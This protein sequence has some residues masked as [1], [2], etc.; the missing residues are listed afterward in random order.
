MQ[1]IETSLEAE[2]FIYKRWIEK[3]VLNYW[4]LR[5]ITQSMQV[6][7]PWHQTPSPV[8]LTLSWAKSQ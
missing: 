8:H 6:V 1:D 7:I 5:Q 4:T 2:F 3:E